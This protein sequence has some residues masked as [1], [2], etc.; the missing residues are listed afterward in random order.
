MQYVLVKDRQFILL[1][2]I[3]WRARFIQSELD[4]LGINF[5]VPQT[6]PV[7]YLQVTSGIEIFRVA[8]KT[9]NH[10]PLYEQ[11]EGPYWNFDSN[12]ADGWYYPIA[13]DLTT[14]KGDL[15]KIAAA[16]RYKKEVAGTKI[17]ING[18]E[19]SL[20]TSREGRAIFNQHI[21]SMTSSSSIE[22]KF[23]E[24]WVTLTKA[25]ITAIISAVSDHIQQQFVW[26]KS[27]GQ[28]IDAA[29]TKEDLSAITIIEPQGIK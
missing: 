22:W 17:T 18:V 15:K 10:D 25:N 8:I 1:G 6:A 9:P 2:P 13:K 29:S 19:V 3:E 23:P 7:D 26:E 24:G 4:D 27:V 12:F 5:T 28:L 11:L 21:T 14:V 20:D 16:E